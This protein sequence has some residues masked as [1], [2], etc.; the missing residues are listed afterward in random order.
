LAGDEE[1]R[2]EIG[3]VRHRGFNLGLSEE[4]NKVNDIFM[5]LKM[6]QSRVT[7]KSNGFG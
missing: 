3:L 4:S 7:K 5:K 2:V 1:L 6:E